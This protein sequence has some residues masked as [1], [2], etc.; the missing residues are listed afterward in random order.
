MHSIGNGEAKLHTLDVPSDI[1]AI[2]CGET[3]FVA[4][5]GMYYPPAN[6][7]PN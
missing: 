1:T 6:D 4:L 2:T 5:S 7:A 3:H